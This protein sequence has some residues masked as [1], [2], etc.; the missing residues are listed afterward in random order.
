MAPYCQDLNKPS[1]D[2]QSVSL[3]I[4]TDTFLVKTGGP[5]QCSEKSNH[6]QYLLLNDDN[7]LGEQH[8]RGTTPS[9]ASRLAMTRFFFFKIKMRPFSGE[10]E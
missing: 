6:A 2:E 4:C 1:S 3:I 8:V 9:L 7:M 10:K 5:K